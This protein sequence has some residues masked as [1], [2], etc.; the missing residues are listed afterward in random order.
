MNIKVKNFPLFIL[1]IIGGLLASCSP[2]APTPQ[3]IAAYPQ[4]S[5]RDWYLPPAHEGG[6]LVYE[7]YLALDVRDPEAAAAE[8]ER[9]AQ[10]FGGY[11]INSYASYSQ[12]TPTITLELR[13]PSH[14]FDAARQSFRSLG[15]LVRETVS[16][17]WNN[18][19]AD[20]ER[21]GQFT[22][23][24]RQQ[25]YPLS[26]PEPLDW[27]PGRTL[28]RALG[29]SVRLMSILIDLLI[30]VVVIL[31]PFALVGWTVLWITRRLPRAAAES[32]PAA[33]Q[34]PESQELDSSSETGG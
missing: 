29:L 17:E 3:Q 24:F 4:S 6:G 23:F 11:L 10:D 13:V 26:L 20:W 2:E 27:N 8:A 9:M 31:G 32:G 21:Y 12:G 18:D 7:A 25:T 14:M 16:G 28:Q 33:S 30:W 15:T 1:V 19:Y 5:G 34:D 22:L